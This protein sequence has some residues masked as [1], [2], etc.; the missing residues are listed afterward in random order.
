MSI[1]FAKLNEACSQLSITI[2]DED[3]YEFLQ[4]YHQII[5][6]VAMALKVLEGDRHPFGLYLPTLIGLRKKLNEYSDRTTANGTY[7][8]VE[9]AGALKDGFENR[10]AHLMD[11]FDSDGRSAPLFIAMATNPEYKLN[12]MGTRTID[13]RVLNRL[14]DMLLTAGLEIN[15]TS[16][17][18][19]VTLSDVTVTSSHAQNK[20]GK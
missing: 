8:C 6:T 3:E 15:T 9:L 7:L 14:K 1:G 5:S 16:Q 12:F 17:S 20:N 19:D 18:K 4:Q 10:F 11:I 2:F 13:P